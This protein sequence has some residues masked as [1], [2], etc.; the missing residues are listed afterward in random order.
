MEVTAACR[1]QAIV[2]QTMVTMAIAWKE[3]LVIPQKPVLSMLDLARGDGRDFGQWPECEER[4][5]SRQRRQLVQRP[6]GKW[7]LG[8]VS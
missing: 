6:W 5:Q 4:E 7:G 1:S 8:S 2:T 3:R